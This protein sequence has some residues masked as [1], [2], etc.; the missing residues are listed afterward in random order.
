MVGGR[1]GRTELR[2]GGEEGGRFI[3]TT[4]FSLFVSTDSFASQIGYS[5]NWHTTS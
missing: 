4:F 1:E 5:I 2:E 3:F